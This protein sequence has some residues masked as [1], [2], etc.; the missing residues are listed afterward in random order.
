M[1]YLIVEGVGHSMVIGG[2]FSLYSAIWSF[3]KTQQAEPIAYT[4]VP[5]LSG[6]GFLIMAASLVL[7]V[8]LQ[9]LSKSAT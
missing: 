2:G 6:E 3:F 8:R 4:E 9:Q 7:L 5:T 1:R